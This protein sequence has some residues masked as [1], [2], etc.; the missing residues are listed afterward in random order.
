[1]SDRGDI[2]RW[3]RDAINRKRG[4]QGGVVLSIRRA[5]RLANEIGRLREDAKDKRRA[6]D[7]DK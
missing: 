1:M 2:Y 7:G 4:R 3:L 6:L 5:E